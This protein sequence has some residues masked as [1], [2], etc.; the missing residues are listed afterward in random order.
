MTTNSHPTPSVVAIVGGAGKT[1]R[2]VAERLA[3]HGHQV[4][5]RSRSTTPSFSWSDPSTADAAL[6]GADAAYVAYAPDLA[7]PDAAE[8]ISAVV[9]AAE[10]AGLG[11]LVLLS[12]RG[13][14]EAEPAEDAVRAFDGEWT[15]LRCSW[16]MQN[17]SEHFLT[18]PVLDGAIALP[19]GDTREPFVDLDD[20]AEVAVAV[21]TEPGHHGATYDL[22][23]PELLDLHGIADHLTQAIGRRIVYVPVTP[24]EYAA[25]AVATGVPEEDVAP[26]TDLFERV[27]DGHNATLSPDLGRLLGRA[28]GRFLDYARRTAPTGVWAVPTLIG[29]P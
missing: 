22:T 24:T 5:L 23:G 6:A 3:D 25:G 18:Q 2:R 16:F 15:V 19:A 14:P 28:P 20:V 1:G 26:L 21:L 12:G 8:Q 27:L 11:R 10:R 13:E 29:Q 7:F 4:R 17:F 9:A